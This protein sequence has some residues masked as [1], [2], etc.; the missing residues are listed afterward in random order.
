VQPSPSN[1][2]TASNSSVVNEHGAITQPI[3]QAHCES[4]PWVRHCANAE[5]HQPSGGLPSR[6][7]REQCPLCFAEMIAAFARYGFASLSPKPQLPNVHLAFRGKFEGFHCAT[8]VDGNFEQ[9]RLRHAGSGDQAIPKGHT[10]FLSPDEVLQAK[11]QV[12]EARKSTKKPAGRPEDPDSTT[13]GLFMANYLYASCS[14]RFLAAEEHNQKS[15]SSVFEDTG[16]MALVCRHD[17]PLFVVTLRDPGERQYNAI[18]LLNRMF[19][20][21][22]PFWRVGVLYDI[23][24][25]MHSSIVKVSLY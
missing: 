11:R 3:V 23:G 1:P 24:C 21:L 18:A 7:L 22:P 17:R 2:L 15:K 12:E 8:C 9:A 20:E 19:M 16:L 10:Y 13:P 25:Q 4:D 6:Y 14:S 5:D